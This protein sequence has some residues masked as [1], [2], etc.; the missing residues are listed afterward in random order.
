MQQKNK[1]I[2]I[3]TA[4]GNPPI[5]TKFKYID[6]K[7]QVVNT[8]K[9][10]DYDYYICEY[11]G[12]EIKI[13]ADKTKMTGGIIIIPETLTKTKPIKMA[14]C[15]KCVKPIIQRFEDRNLIMDNRNHIP[16]IW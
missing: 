8:Q 6:S 14:L 12:S 13:E 4:I 5:H 15:N 16:I 1:F 10:K 2:K 11:C 3:N 9:I 7:S